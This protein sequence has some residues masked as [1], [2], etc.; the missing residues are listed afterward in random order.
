[1]RRIRRN[2]RAVGLE[3]IPAGLEAGLGDK[4]NTTPLLVQDGFG[5]G[6]AELPADGL[7]YCGP[8]AA[9][10]SLLWL[11][12]NGWNQIGPAAPTQSDALDLDLLLAGLADT[13]A[14][15]GTYTDNLQNAV[16]AYLNA[17]GIPSSAFTYP[18]GTNQPSLDIIAQLNQSQTVVTLLLGWYTPLSAGS[19]T[20]QRV[21]GHFVAIL[22]QQEPNPEDL[23]IGN[24]CPS[25][26]ELV[27]D[28][29]AFALQTLPTSNFTGTSADLPAPP[30]SGTFYLQF[31]D[32]TWSGSTQAV[33]PVLETVFALTVDMSEQSRNGPPPAQWSLDPAQTIDTNGAPLRVLAPLAGA[34]GLIKQG[35]GALTLCASNATTGPNQIAGGSLT[36]A[37]ISGA[38]GA[39]GI[40]MS[41]GVLVADPGGSGAEVAL[42]V[43][44]GQNAQFSF[45][46]STALQLVI[47]ENAGLAVTLGGP[48]SAGGPGLVQAGP[49]ALMISVD[50]GAAALGA[51][52]TLSVPAGIGNLA[53]SSP[54]VAPSIVA[55]SPQSAGTVDFLIYGES[56]FVLPSYTSSTQTDINSASASD[57]YSVDDAQ[58]L[59]AEAIA[60]VFALKA[61]QYEVGAAG[62][63]AVLKVGPQQAGQTTGVILNGATLTGFELDLGASDA[64]VYAS[65]SA[66]VEAVISGSGQLNFFGPGTLSLTGANVCTGGVLVLSGT[67]GVNNLEGSGTGTGQVTVQGAG[68]LSLEGTVSGAISAEDG[69]TIILQSGT[70]ASS[71]NVDDQSILAGIGYVA[72]SATI[73]GQILAG[74]RPGS[75]EFQGAVTMTGTTIFAWTLFD[76]ED[77]STVGPD[78]QWNSLTFTGVGN[79]LNLG[80][81]NNWVAVILDMTRLGSRDPNSDH[82]FWTSSHTW[83]LFHSENTAFDSI[84]YG[85][86][87]PQF[88]A[89]YFSLTS[90]PNYQFMYLTFM[91]SV[92]G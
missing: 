12:K 10:M 77:D 19:S 49:G 13:S 36:S 38:F 48:A 37:G 87:Q 73:D 5:Y 26:L 62:A 22:G 15:G 11:G 85:L 47:G 42:A 28:L 64:A 29:P 63:N 53:S 16:A 41:G 1:M 70:A 14:L 61:G 9:A 33:T 74:S 44:G 39:G 82:E 51:A 21:G 30:A 84:W 34:G 76:L 35:D 23:I 55:Q 80:Q 3:P 27:P 91:P 81:K 45:S 89:G 46:G 65:G 68:I 88:K 52:C 18:S 2:L 60:S 31:P 78:P 72:G 67:L 90:D 50:A 7:S 59:G 6:G 32:V 79:T 92:V 43:A 66:L 58:T 57:V 71:L 69:A 75:V 54:I 24:P 56:G 40:A 86:L 17:G 20:F 25:S 4:V 83:T 8:T